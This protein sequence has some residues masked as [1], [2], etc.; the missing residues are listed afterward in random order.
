MNT[1]NFSLRIWGVAQLLFNG[2][3]LLLSAF[4][5]I[6]LMLVPALAGGLC[7]LFFF[8]LFLTGVITFTRKRHVAFLLLSLGIVV[9]CFIPL[10]GFTWLQSGRLVLWDSHSGLY[11]AILVAAVCGIVSTAVH[12]RDL[13]RMQRQYPL[14][15]DRRHG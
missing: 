4:S 10:Y 9:S 8:F 6:P 1:I 3:S 13:F 12:Y 2:L 15:A 7:S 14:L 11:P 5:V